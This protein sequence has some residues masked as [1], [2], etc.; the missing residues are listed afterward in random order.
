MTHLKSFKDAL[1]QFVP[2]REQE[3]AYYKQFAKFLEQYEDSKDKQSRTET[4]GGNSLSHVRLVSGHNG[5]LKEKL[6]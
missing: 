3:N 5:A 1:K 4:Q 6:D 2:L